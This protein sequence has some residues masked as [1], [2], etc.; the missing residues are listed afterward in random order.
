MAPCFDFSAM[1]L[2]QEEELMAR[3]K[4]ARNALKGNDPDTANA[5]TNIRE[6]IDILRKSDESNPLKVT[7]FLRKKSD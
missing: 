6:A 4:K 2:E 7:V 1:T 5:L 3:L